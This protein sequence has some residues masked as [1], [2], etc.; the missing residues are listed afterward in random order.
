MGKP[1]RSLFHA[2]EDTHWQQLKDFFFQAVEVPVAE[3]AAWMA[4]IDDPHLQAA[5]ARLLA[6]DADAF[7]FLAQLGVLPN[8]LNLYVAYRTMDVG[9]V[10]DS[11]FDSWT[12]GG[13]YMLNQNIR[14]ELFNVFEDGSGVDAR[15]SERDQKLVLQVFIGF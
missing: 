1:F 14:F 3:R 15:S 9:K 10:T 7:G 11:E 2:M 12:I 13:N 4:Q 8:K 6:D 5:L